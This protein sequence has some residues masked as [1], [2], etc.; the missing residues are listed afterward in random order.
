MTIGRLNISKTFNTHYC[1]QHWLNLKKVM[2]PSMKN[3][4]KSLLLPTTLIKT[5]EK[6]YDTFREGEEKTIV[7]NN[8]RSGCS[9]INK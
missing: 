9:Q 7:V 6:N 3:E 2:T 1:Q 5:F 4:K 8:I